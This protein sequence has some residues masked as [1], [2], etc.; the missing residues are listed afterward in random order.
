MYVALLLALLL[1]PAN[2]L[3]AGDVTA[4]VTDGD[5]ELTGDDAA[6]VFR[7]APAG[8]PQSVIVTGL[9][10]T[11]VNGGTGALTLNGVISLGLFPGD[12][13]DRMELQLLDLPDRLLAKLGRGNDGLILQDVRVRG[14]VSRI[15]GGADRDDITIRGFTQFGERLVIGTGAG[16]DSVTLTN[17][18]FSRGL[19]IDT[20]GSRDAVVLQFCGLAHAEELLV[21]TGDGEDA[22]TLLGSN[23]EDDVKLD[24]DDGDDDLLVEDCDFDDKFDADGGDGF[25]EIDFDGEN[26][27]EPLERRRVRDFETL[28]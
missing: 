8:A 16:P 21:R 26:T 25:D 23:F 9:E 15:R 6:N 13:D 12:G 24:L 27:F 19:R 4:V 1:L 14:R 17:V 7:V 5:L 3:A 20:G 10:G 11:T 28:N 2:V 18:G 22:V